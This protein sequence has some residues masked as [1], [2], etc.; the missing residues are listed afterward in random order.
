MRIC[1]RDILPMSPTFYKKEVDK[2]KKR[3]IFPLLAAVFMFVSGSI[4]AYAYKYSRQQRENKSFF[5][6]INLFFVKCW[7]HW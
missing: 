1:Y 2:M 5:H 6:F 7:G 4:T 3:L